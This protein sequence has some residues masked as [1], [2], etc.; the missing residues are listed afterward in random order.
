MPRQRYV[1]A[2]VP[3]R[4]VYSSQALTTGIQ[5]TDS[6]SEVVAVNDLY[7]VVLPRL[8]N[9]ARQQERKTKRSEQRL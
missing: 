6:Q 4:N 3:G 9:H 7:D 1:S 5:A 2:F 8:R